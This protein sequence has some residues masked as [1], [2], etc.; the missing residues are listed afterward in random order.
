[1]ATSS[2]EQRL[3]DSVQRSIV[4]PA[5]ELAHQLHLSTRGISLDWAGPMHHLSDCEC[6]DLA[7]GVQAP[8]A[9]AKRN[10]A[11][12]ETKQLKRLFGVAPGLFV[13]EDGQLRILYR[14]VVLVHNGVDGVK[15]GATVM[16]W[17]AAVPTG[18][19]EVLPKG[20]AVV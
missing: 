13:H 15:K 2:Q 12:G 17:L 1:M 20:Q 9:P 8:A 6:I 16:S 4:E 10:G 7:A 3:K 11:T 14:P 18:T 5:V 19:D